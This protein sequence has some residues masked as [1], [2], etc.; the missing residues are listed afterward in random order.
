M[1]LIGMGLPQKYSY[2]TLRDTGWGHNKN[3]AWQGMYTTAR[4]NLY[5]TPFLPPR[6]SQIFIGIGRNCTF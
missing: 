3:E 6:G 5:M 2:V 4:V 1:H